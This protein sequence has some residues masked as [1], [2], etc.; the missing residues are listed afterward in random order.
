MKLTRDN[1]GLAQAK[2]IRVHQNVR[3]LKKIMPT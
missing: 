2:G 1:I 3:G